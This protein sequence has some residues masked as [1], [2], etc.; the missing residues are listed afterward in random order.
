MAAATVNRPAEHFEITLNPF[1]HVVVTQC[2]RRSCSTGHPS[3][4]ILKAGSVPQSFA[5]DGGKT[6]AAMPMG[7]K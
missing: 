2:C 7:A 3:E 1:L 4:L 5:A 6:R